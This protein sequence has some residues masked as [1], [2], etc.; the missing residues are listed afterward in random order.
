M[1]YVLRVSLPDTP[2]SLH[3]VAGI[4]GDAGADIVS[5]AVIE[6]SGGFAIDDLCVTGIVDPTALRGAIDAL[7]GTTVTSVRPTATTRDVDGAIALAAALV[8]GGRGAVRLLVD[9][10]PAALWA[11]WAVAV[12]NGWSG[13]EVLA[14]SAGALPP[15]HGGWLP[16][17]STRRLDPVDLGG[18]VEW[19]RDLEIAA[20]PL[21]QTTSAV[22]V[23]RRGGPRFVERERWQLEL[24]A[25]VAVA[26]EVAH[27]PRRPVEHFAPP[28]RTTV[29]S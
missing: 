19:D 22:L 16:L 20:A 23:A 9:R 10:L 17:T 5:L 11:S 2:G 4:C 21:G 6:R 3:A 28:P 8:A 7:P 25:Q 15:V 29:R 24:L 14:A 12:A 13:M 27:T 26:T 1:H 18:G